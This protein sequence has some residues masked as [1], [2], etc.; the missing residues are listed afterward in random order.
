MKKN[1]KILLLTALIITGIVSCDKKDDITVDF[2]ASL[3]GLD[4]VF[5]A[6]GGEGKLEIVSEGYWIIKTDVPWISVSPL[7]GSGSATC[8]VK[9]DSSKIVGP[10]R[11]AVI[12]VINEESIVPK[13]FT[14]TLE[15]YEKHIEIIDF[16]EITLPGYEDPKKRVDRKSTRL[17]PSHRPLPRMPSSA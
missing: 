12:Q 14:I 3:P 16:K 5:G 10:D 8:I 17:N 13:E 1:I 15:S 2:D 4:Q 6:D 11:S 7:N 9:I